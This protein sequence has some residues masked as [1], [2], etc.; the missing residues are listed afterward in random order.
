M[1]KAKTRRSVP[2]PPSNPKPQ[3]QPPVH[4][5][6][7]IPHAKLHFDLIHPD[8]SDVPHLIDHFRR[9]QTK[10]LSHVQA[11]EIDYTRLHRIASLKP[12]KW[13]IG[14]E[15]WLGYIL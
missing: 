11:R 5:L 7:A 14:S 6:D 13:Y 8:A 12:S 10:I 15:L 4:S 1:L 3:T 9:H 2:A